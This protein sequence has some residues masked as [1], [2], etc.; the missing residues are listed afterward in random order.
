MERRQLFF[1]FHFFPKKRR[2]AWNSP[3]DTQSVASRKRKRK[4]EK[5]TDVQVK[6]ESGFG[7]NLRLVKKP[8]VKVEPKQEDAPIPRNFQK[9]AFQD[10][11]ALKEMFLN[12]I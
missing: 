2:F 8:V 9:E 5:G 11:R 6:E 4:V 12:A 3:R 10:K 7:N 1:S